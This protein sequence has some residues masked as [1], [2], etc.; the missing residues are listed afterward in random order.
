MNSISPIKFDPEPVESRLVLESFSR[1]LFTPSESNIED[2]QPSSDSPASRNT[3]P[4]EDNS[5]KKVIN[6]VESAEVEN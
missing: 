3:S 6:K 5:S 2:I 1:K 4:N